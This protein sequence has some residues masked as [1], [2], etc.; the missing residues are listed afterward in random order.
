MKELYQDVEDIDLFVGLLKEFKLA[1]SLVGPTSFCIL[2]DTF[3]RY[4]L[5]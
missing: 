1:E 5:P 2:T 3:Q 4:K